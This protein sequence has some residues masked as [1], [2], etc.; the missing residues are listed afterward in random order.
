MNSTV[1]A[2]MLMIP[3]TFLPATVLGVGAA[4]C[5]T[6]LSQRVRAGWLIAFQCSLALQLYLLGIRYGYGVEAVLSIQ[7][8]SGVLIPPLAY[9]A[10]TNPSWSSR[11]WAHSLS[12]LVMVLVVIFAPYLADALLGGVTLGY[13]AALAIVLWREGDELFAWA[14]LQYTSALRLG[15]Y[16][17]AAILVL[18]GAT[19]AVI[20]ADFWVTGG[21]RTGAIAAM[22]S[23]AGVAL[24]AIGLVVLMRFD[25]TKTPIES[26]DA[27]AALVQS[28]RDEIT[29]KELYRDPDLTLT[30][31]SKRLA[32]PARDISQAVNRTTGLNM[33]QFINNMR[34]QAACDMLAK[35]DVSITTAMLDAGFYTKSNFNRE[36]R[37]VMGET[38]TQWRKSRGTDKRQG[39]S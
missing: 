7:H 27:D 14:P 5:A 18:S 4:W 11:V 25:F 22:A 16:G 13:A 6:R 29:R 19:D 12:V 9:L 3:I 24:L 2:A 10:F 31:L 28:L 36:F 1:K 26:T 34:I 30:R 33:S 23:F 8:L 21:N 38:P 17:S 35:T 39:R 15:L 37:R 20:M 32:H